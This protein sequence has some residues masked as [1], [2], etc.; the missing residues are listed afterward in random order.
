MFLCSMTEIPN[1]QLKIKVYW[2]VMLC[3]WTSSSWRWDGS[4]CLQY[5]TKYLS[6][7]T[8][9]HRARPNLIVTLLKEI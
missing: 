3:P 2:Y 7:I 9:Q 5:D 4:M 1:K 8:A 6:S